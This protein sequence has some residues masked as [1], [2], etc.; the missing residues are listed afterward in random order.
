MPQYNFACDCG[1]KQSVIR[2]M[3]DYKK[4]LKCKCGEKMYRVYNFSVGGDTYSKP[5]V[6]DS[7]AI[8][9]TQIAE[10]KK[11]FPDVKV[12]PDGQ[13]VFDNFKQHESYLEKTGFVKHT[14]KLKPKSKTIVKTK[15]S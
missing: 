1:E 14:Q 12:T 11:H 8:S 6:S 3:K 15:L 13:P 4:P 10:H 9:P 5:I 2:S 7:L